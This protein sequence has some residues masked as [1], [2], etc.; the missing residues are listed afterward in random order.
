M[1]NELIE[2]LRKVGLVKR[3]PQRGFALRGVKNPQTV[4]AHG[5]REAIMGWMIARIS[6]SGFDC[7]RVMKIALVHDMCAGYA[8]D[9]TPYEFLL[10]KQNGKNVKSVF[11][12]WIRLSKKEKEKILESQRRKERKACGQLV[13]RLPK[14]LQSEIGGLW[15]EFEKGTTKEGRFVQQLDMF[16]NFLEATHQWKHDEKFPIDPWWHQMKELINDP[17]LVDFL[18]HMDERTLLYQKKRRVA[19]KK[20]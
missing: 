4:G 15:D 8:G 13:K 20:K 2:F 5:F 14:L 9:L 19:Q 17:V 7:N 18:K 10:K 6:Y 12:S 16:E 11:Q 3:M 1:T